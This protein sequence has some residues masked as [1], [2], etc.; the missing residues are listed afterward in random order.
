MVPLYKGRPRLLCKDVG[1]SNR[2]I[3]QDEEERYYSKNNRVFCRNVCR[4]I[5]KGRAKYARGC[6]I[7]HNGES[8]AGNKNN[9]KQFDRNRGK[10]ECVGV[11]SQSGEA[12]HCAGNRPMALFEGEEAGRLLLRFRGRT[13]NRQDVSGESG[14]VAMFK[15]REWRSEAFSHHCVGRMQQQ[16]DVGG[17]QLYLFQFDVGAH[18]R[19]S[20]GEQVHESHHLHRRAGQGEQDGSRK[21]NHRHSHTHHRQQSKFEFPGQ[22][23]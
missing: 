13:R 2:N 21:G 16:F 17:A 5:H 14:T 10:F 8:Y 1:R 15:G 23:F 19:H 18:R 11:W 22:I 9:K 3:K 20:H 7:Q 4:C 12:Q 6:K